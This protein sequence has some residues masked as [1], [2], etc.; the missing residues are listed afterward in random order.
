MASAA[1]PVL[2]GGLVTTVMWWL[3]L[4]LDLLWFTGRAVDELITALL[5]VPAVLPRV[6]RWWWRVQAD[7]TAYRSG[8][9]EAEI[10]Q[11]VWR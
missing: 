1:G 6:R 4:L 3:R 10:A 2:D 9:V 7:W 5:G 11:G 8:A